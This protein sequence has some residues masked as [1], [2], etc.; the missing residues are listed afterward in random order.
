[1]RRIAAW[2]V[3]LALIATGCSTGDRVVVAAG[4][5][6]V[7]SQFMAR[8]LEEYAAGVQI[9]VLGVSS[10][11]ALAL[12]A[13]GSA[14]VLITH[15]PEAE[16]AFLADHP[17]A[18][19]QTVFASHFVLVGP[20]APQLGTPDAVESLE[21]I[22]EAGHLFV[23]RSDGSG[24]A[25]KE[26]EL[27]GIAGVDPTG[28]SWY[29]ETG[30]GM[31][32]TLQVADQRGAFTLAEI[33][34]FVA[35]ASISLVPVGE[36]AEDERLANPYRITLVEGASDEARAFFDWMISDEGSAAVVAANVEL[37]DDLLYAPA[38]AS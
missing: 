35:T 38:L 21:L 8:V 23:S 30:Q 6:L 14:E 18:E 32:F 26:R 20:E 9:S 29:T 19:Q 16:E 13:S 24:T 15:L 2:S 34:S 37:F 25:A 11:E 1:V 7:D 27:W 36:A 31:G 33:G 22:A 28:R 3:I 17:D 12:G 10:L 5:T 4:T